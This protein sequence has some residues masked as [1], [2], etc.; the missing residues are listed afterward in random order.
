MLDE[1][2]IP[3]TGRWLVIP[4]W[5]ASLIKRTDLRNASISGDGVSLMRNGRLGM[6][7]RFTLYT[8]NLLP[9]A[10]DGAG[11]AMRIFAGTTL[12]LTFASR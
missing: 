7:D 11:N 4:P 10:V 6:M 3:E 8:S 12:W 1:Q 5:A 2:N 9:T